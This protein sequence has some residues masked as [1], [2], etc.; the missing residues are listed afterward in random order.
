VTGHSPSGR[1]G[2]DG[3]TP[4]GETAGSSG[5]W[6]TGQVDMQMARRVAAAMQSHSLAAAVGLARNGNFTDVRRLLDIGG[7][8]GCYAIALAQ[9]HPELRCSVM[10]LPAMCEVAHQYIRD[11]EVEDRVDTVAVDM[12]R[13]P[14]PEG[15]DA[16]FFSNVW[17][18]WNFE[19]CAWLAEQSFNALPSGGRIYLHEMLLN[20]DGCGPLTAAS[21]SMLMLNTQGQ[22]FTFPEL[23]RLLEGAGF[24]GVE[25]RQTSVYYSLVS[26][27]KP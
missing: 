3:A 1:P 27:R 4:L 2:T 22:Q 26:A 8:S 21:F 5:G 12:F 19:T 9:R 18:D 17:H 14:W 24:V 11:G 20:D 15:C 6:A 7:G 23:K 13:E 10:E 25:T 16:L